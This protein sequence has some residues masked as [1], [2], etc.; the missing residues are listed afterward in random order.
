MSSPSGSTASRLVFR[1][2]HIGQQLMQC[3]CFS[4]V[5]ATLWIL[6]NSSVLPGR[7][8]RY[9]MCPCV[10]RHT[11]SPCLAVHWCTE[12][13][14]LPGPVAWWWGNRTALETSGPGDWLCLL[15][16]SLVL[17]GPESVKGQERRL[18]SPASSPSASPRQHC[19]SLGMHPGSVREVERESLLLA[20]RAAQLT[21]AKQL[22]CCLPRGGP[23]TLQAFLPGL[24][25]AEC[26]YSLRVNI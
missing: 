18:S 11:F 5:Q 9:Q 23:C 14:R 7:E 24:D 6:C 2:G 4:V 15:G 10:C 21:W 17:L 26:G 8:D 12:V 25:S 1:P 13:V 16:F 22:P 19:P 20:S 3:A